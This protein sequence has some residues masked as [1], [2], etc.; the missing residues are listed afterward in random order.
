[1]PFSLL[2]LFRPL[3]R[4]RNVIVSRVQLGLAEVQQSSL[5][6]N[7]SPLLRT[8]TSL[9]PHAVYVSSQTDNDVIDSL[10]SVFHG[11]DDSSADSCCDAG[12][13]ASVYHWPAPSEMMQEPPS[14]FS[15]TENIH[16]VSVQHF[17]QATVSP[18]AVDPL[19]YRASEQEHRAVETT[20]SF[21]AVIWIVWNAR[22]AS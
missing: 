9:N 17:K 4:Q 8:I 14:S 11:L 12:S 18:R 5:T 22:Q 10:R 1:M 19:S 7:E 15:S 16:L 3:V 2:F 13:D 6:D 20:G 21:I